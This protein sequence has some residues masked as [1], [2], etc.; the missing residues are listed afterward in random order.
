[1]TLTCNYQLPA[2]KAAFVGVGLQ[3]PNQGLVVL[4]FLAEALYHLSFYL[5]TLED[6]ALDINGV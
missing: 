4:N 3:R 5:S 1:M 6:I 2:M